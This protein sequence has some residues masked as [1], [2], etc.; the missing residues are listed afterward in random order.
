[1]MSSKLWKAR[2]V[3]ALI[4]CREKAAELGGLSAKFVAAQY[5][6]RHALTF[7]SAPKTS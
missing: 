7:C 5:I 4:V 3:E 1:M 6:S 2:E